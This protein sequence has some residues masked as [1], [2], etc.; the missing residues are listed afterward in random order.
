MDLPADHPAARPTVELTDPATMRVLAHPTRLRLLGELRVHG[1]CSVGT[2]S[3][4]VDE[5]PGSVSYHLSR[6]AEVGLVA[7]APEHAPDRRQRWWRSVH[8]FTRTP[9]PVDTSDPERSAA[10]T[11]LRKSFVRGL[12]DAHE[13]Y[14]DAEHDLTPDWAQASDSGDLSL[15]LTADELA[16]MAREVR[17]VW[18]RWLGRSDR[19]RE[20]TRP[21]LAL[22]AL[23][24][25]P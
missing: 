13:A 3:R 1:P 10:S 8:V 20:G 19:D 21:V 15:D 9:S 11:A 25:R 7:E 22:Y 24:P 4:A 2:L 23:F 14:L 12:A 6:L 17:D 16:Q 18:Q 5:A